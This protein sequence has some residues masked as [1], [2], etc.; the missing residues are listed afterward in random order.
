M[1]VQFV[2]LTLLTGLDIDSIPV[3]VGPRGRSE[4]RDNFTS[5]SSSANS[6]RNASSVPK[7]PSPLGPLRHQARSGDAGVSFS[8]IWRARATS[9]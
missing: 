9:V 4:S 1:A 5:R 7:G 3:T 8:T 6:F 2:E